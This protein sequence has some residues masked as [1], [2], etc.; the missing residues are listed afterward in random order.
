MIHHFLFYFLQTHRVLGYIVVFVA[1]IFE[2]DIFLFT[3]A[4]LTSQGFFD[5]INMFVAI[6]TG[7]LSGDLFW[8][9]V[10]LRLRE[11]TGLITTWAKRIAAPFDDHLKQRTAHTIFLSKFIYGVHHAILIRAG[12]LKI[13]L[14]KFIKIDFISTLAWIII[15]GGLGF[16]SSISFDKIKH[17]IRFLEGT[18]LVAAICFLLF[19]YLISYQVKKK[20]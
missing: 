4:F 14:N 12:M 15:V 18:F 11:Q 3:A 5:P 19:S 17:Q 8:Y 1:M 13:R 2:G 16:A 10:G 7:V 6:I 20:L 9:W